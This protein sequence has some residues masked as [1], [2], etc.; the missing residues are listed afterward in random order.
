MSNVTYDTVAVRREARKFQSCRD[1]LNDDVLPKIRTVRSQL[2][3]NFEGDAAN[4]LKSRLDFECKRA[5]ALYDSCD[6]LYRAMMRYADELEEK[7]R[8]IAQMLK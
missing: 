1:R 7:D 3:G 2:D 5:R 6:L 8:R 4:A